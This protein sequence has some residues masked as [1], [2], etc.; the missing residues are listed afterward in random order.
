VVLVSVC[1]E[2]GARF[3]D[4]G[5]DVLVSVCDEDGARFEE[6]RVVDVEPAKDMAEA[7]TSEMVD[8]SSVVDTPT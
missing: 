4:V 6:G 8:A 2:D 3:E 5:E 1:D 7:A